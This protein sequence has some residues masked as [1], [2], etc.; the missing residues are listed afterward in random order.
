MP[1][2]DYTAKI[3]AA[4]KYGYSD[5]D[6]VAHLML[7]DPKV[8]Q[9]VDSGYKPAEIINF[10]STPQQP[11]KQPSVFEQYVADPAVSTAAGFG[12][13]AKLREP[14]FAAGSHD[15]GEGV[16]GKALVGLNEHNRQFA[17]VVGG[18]RLRALAHEVLKALRQI[19]VQ[20]NDAIF[21]LR[22]HEII[23][24]YA[25]AHFDDLFLVH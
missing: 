23:I 22:I 2:V 21:A 1:P 25:G 20:W 6:I 7:N 12:R 18:T 17:V 19:S 5:D 11:V 15:L 24:K 13:E 14:S 9:A 3:N 16:V 4:R 8:K 10:I